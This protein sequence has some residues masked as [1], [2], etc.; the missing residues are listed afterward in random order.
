MNNEPIARAIDVG[1]GNT[2]FTVSDGTNGEIECQ[3]FPSVAPL[4]SRK[5]LEAHMG[6]RDT[7]IVDVDGVSYEVGPDAMLGMASNA[8]RTLNLDFAK[9]PTYMALVRGAMHYM[10]V[11]RIDHLFL[12]LPVSSVEALGR[13]LS[14]RMTG[15]HQLPGRSVCV[16]ECKVIPQPVGGMY[17]Y[18]VRNQILRELQDAT[19]L[20]IDPGYFTLDWVMTQGLKMLGVRS[21]AANNAGMAAIL[22]QVSQSL[23][24]SIQRRESKPADITESS[25]QRM[26]DAIR[27]NRPFRFMGKVED[28]TP[29]MAAGR[30][31]VVDALNSLVQSIGSKNDI[32]NV[33]IVGGSAHLYKDDVAEL[34]KGFD[35]R[36]ATHAIFA[37]VRGFQMMASKRAAQVRREAAEVAK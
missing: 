16:H 34:F 2:K 35:V 32:D 20:L 9:T 30:K 15:T 7:A 10:Q 36:V 29:H 25:L 24:D 6:P 8:S 26:D 21:G 37:N 12:G 1:Y 27:L 23:A 22:R 17:D 18:G 33:I 19:N 3:M 5:A 31:V 11:D 14:E 13:E 28:L 4:S